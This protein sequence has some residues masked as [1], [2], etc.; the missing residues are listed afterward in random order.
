M[1]YDD[2]NNLMRRA[3]DARRKT[4]QY[5]NNPA[6]TVPIYDLQQPILDDWYL[7]VY[8]TSNFG[9]QY[10]D[11]PFL[12]YLLPKDKE[13]NYP[14]HVWVRFTLRTDL[15]YC[16]PE[17]ANYIGFVPE[18][19][20]T[21]DY[22]CGDHNNIQVW[23]RLPQFQ[24]AF[25][26]S[27]GGFDTGYYLGVHAFNTSHGD[28]DILYND[29]PSNNPVTN[30]GG[31]RHVI[32][33][34]VSFSQPYDPQAPYEGPGGKWYTE[35]WMSQP[36]GDPVGRVRWQSYEGI[37]GDTDNI[38]GSP[39][40][41]QRIPLG[42][43]GHIAAITIP[44]HYG[45]FAEALGNWEMCL[46]DISIGRGRGLNDIMGPLTFQPPGNDI[47]PFVD[48]PWDGIDEYGMPRDPTFVVEEKHIP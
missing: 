15:Q 14:D 38:V 42:A 24:L 4:H 20:I 43:A 16:W 31:T 21:Y 3:H 8:D 10:F 28:S 37:W 7:A 12:H 25:R 6:P 30:L 45:D 40:N 32:D 11:Q 18:E 33:T 36:P 41:G 19:A 48:D 1:P 26:H 17:E 2:Y 35:V 5:K 23:D 22:Y 34:Y 39:T 13:G 9:G 27:S 29:P 47:A 46:D 44:H